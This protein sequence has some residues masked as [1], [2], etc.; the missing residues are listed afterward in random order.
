MVVGNTF[1]VI[2]ELLSLLAQILLFTYGGIEVYNGNLSVGVLIV[3][4]N[5]FSSLLQSANFFL[6]LGQSYQEALSSFDRLKPYLEMK[7]LSY[8]EKKIE[9]LTEISLNKLSFGYFEKKTLFSINWTL[10]CGKIYWLR[11]KNGAGKSSLTNL[12]LGLFG[13]DYLGEIKYEKENVKDIDFPEL[14]KKHT[15][16]VEQVPY[17]L[18][19]TLRENLYCKCSGVRDDEELNILLKKFGMYEFIEKQPEGLDTIYD[20]Q[21]DTMSGGEKQKI[22]LIRLFLSDAELRILDE[23]TAALDQSSKEKF[24]TELKRKQKD[25]ITILITHEQPPIFDK[26]IN[27]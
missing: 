7:Q 25:C 17:L 16:I 9:K 27:L 22:A 3:V 18:A 15:V 12:L 11:G 10:T 8:G 21:N 5:Y 14:I 20:S 2:I 1:N 19:D 23:P 4:M 13:L 26:I 6:N 24:Y